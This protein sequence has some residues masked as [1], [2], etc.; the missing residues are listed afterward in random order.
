M[1]PM[2]SAGHGDGEESSIRHSGLLGLLRR[3]GKEGL[4][5][6]LL[7]AGLIMS[8]VMPGRGR[9]RRTLTKCPE[10]ITV[11]PWPHSTQAI[12]HRFTMGYVFFF[13]RE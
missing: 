4:T 5:G 6:H 10:G 9:T 2:F 11:Y 8:L 1:S 12:L 3:R 7:S 13:L